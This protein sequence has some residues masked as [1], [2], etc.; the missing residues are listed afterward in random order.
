MAKLTLFHGT[1][2]DFEGF[3]RRYALRGSEP[4]SALGIH[5]T[6]RPYVAAD[7]AEL[8]ARDRHAG[9]PRVLVVEVDIC[10]AALVDSVEEFLGRPH[11]MPLDPEG[12]RTR[13]E[14]VAARHELEALGFEAVA[15]DTA[16][17]DLV[18]TW[19]VFDPEKVRIV[20]RLTVDEAIELEE[21]G[22]ETDW[23]GVD[24]V[25]RTIF[26]NE[27]FSPRRLT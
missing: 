9:E 22:H 8:A 14:F 2:H 19:V 1:A 26:G 6:E 24:L 20:G 21:S 11:D 16:M 5:L 23:S 7:Y 4:N 25:S 3:D 13:E 18:G 27:S 12:T 15:L 10:R 17:E